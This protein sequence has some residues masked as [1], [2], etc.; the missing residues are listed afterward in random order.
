MPQGY[1][2]APLAVK[3]LTNQLFLKFSNQLYTVMISV[4]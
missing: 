1:Y 2:M 4:Q 3:G